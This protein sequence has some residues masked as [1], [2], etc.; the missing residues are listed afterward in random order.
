MN[1]LFFVL[2]CT[3]ALVA[4][5]NNYYGSMTAPVT[6]AGAIIKAKHMA[7]VTPKYKRKDCPVCKGE[8]WYISGDDITKVDCGYCEP[9]KTSPVKSGS[10]TKI[11]VSGSPC[12]TGSCTTTTI[13]K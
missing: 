13:K 4:S 3:A 7:D 5:E 2:F 1:K 8:G 11:T 6:I 10:T 12:L 9:D